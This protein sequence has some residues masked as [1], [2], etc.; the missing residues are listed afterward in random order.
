[1]C[2]TML[3]PGDEWRFSPA[4]RDSGA[5][6]RLAALATRQFGRVRWDQIRAA[7]VG[8]TTIGRWVAEGYLQPRLPRVY[9]VGHTAPSH[10]AAHCEALL[11]AGPGAMLGHASGLWWWQVLD[12]PAYPIQI[13]TPRRVSSRRGVEVHCRRSLA[14]VQLRG[15]AVTTVDQALL[16]FASIASSDRLRFALANADYLNLL[17][18]DELEALMGRGTK[19]T[20]ALRAA[21]ALHRPQLAHTRS[22]LERRLVSLAERY[23]LPA[24][25]CNVRLHG[26]LVDALWADAKLVVELD[27]YR[28]HRSP[29]QLRRDHQR[30]LELRARGY[31]VLRYSWDQLTNAP[32]DVAADIRRHLGRR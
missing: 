26:Y 23:A 13:S 29:A 12:R 20:V 1:M 8:K 21:L 24:P 22:E 16:D 4:G 27:G 28:A 3:G 2:R 32:G 18:L 31:V 9:A 10:E 19:G 11:Y 14:R 25:R 15:L 5:K 6:V 17:R 7:G 30:D